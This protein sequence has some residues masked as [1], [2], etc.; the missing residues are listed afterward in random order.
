MTL[1]VDVA[2]HFVIQLY[3]FLVVT[4]D[5]DFVEVLDGL[6]RS[7]QLYKHNRRLLDRNIPVILQLEHVLPNG[8]ADELAVAHEEVKATRDLDT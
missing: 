6:A 2:A 8:V 4:I 5:L 1:L 3:E 7:A